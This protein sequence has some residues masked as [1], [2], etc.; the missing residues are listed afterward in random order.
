MCDLVK[1]FSILNF[2]SFEKQH[3]FLRVSACWLRVT[4]EWGKRKNRLSWDLETVVN[5][6]SDKEEGENT[7]A[8]HPKEGYPAET[9]H[10]K[11]YSL[12]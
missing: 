3:T 2:A 1:Q 9:M 10:I 5:P 8:S 11:I 4:L 12:L 6:F 7:I